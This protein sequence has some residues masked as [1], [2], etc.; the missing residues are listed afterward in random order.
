MAVFHRKAVRAYS[1]MSLTIH[2]R[3]LETDNGVK[4]HWKDTLSFVPKYTFNDIA[5][6]SEDSKHSTVTHVEQSGSKAP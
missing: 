4:L 6:V 2:N 5:C 3:P 1:K